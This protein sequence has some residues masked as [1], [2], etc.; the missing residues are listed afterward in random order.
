MTIIE[1]KSPVQRKVALSDPDAS[2]SYSYIENG[3][4]EMTND[5]QTK[6]FG[7]NKEFYVRKVEGCSV[8]KALTGV[9]GLSKGGFLHVDRNVSN[10][11]RDHLLFS[12]DNSIYVLRGGEQIFLRDVNVSDG[13]SIERMAAEQWRTYTH[14]VIGDPDMSAEAYRYTGEQTGAISAFADYSATVAGTI[15][16]TAAAHGFVTGN[17]VVISGTTNYN[18]TY[19][20]TVIDADTFYVTAVWVADDGASVWVGL[21][22]SLETETAMSA[23]RLLG[24]MDETMVSGGVEENSGEGLYSKT[25]VSGEFGDFTS[26]TG[27]GDGGE[28]SGILDTINAMKYVKGYCAVAEENTVTFH[29]RKIE[30]DLVLGTVKRSD[31]QDK[32]LTLT[33]VGTKSPK[34]LFLDSALFILD[35]IRK[36]VFQYTVS[37]RP[38]LIDLGKDIFPSMKDYD[39]SK[40]E[41][42]VDPDKNL[43]L[44]RV[45]SLAGGS[46]DTTLIYNF[47]SKGWSIDVDKN[48]QDMVFNPITRKILAFDTESAQILEIFDGGYSNLGEPISVKWRTRPINGGDEYIEKEYDTS[49]VKFGY[50]SD[51]QSAKINYYIDEQTEPDVTDEFDMPDI[52]DVGAG[53]GLGVWGKN[54]WGEGSASLSSQM[55]FKRKLNEDAVTDFSRLIIEITETSSAPFAAYKPKAVVLP[56][57]NESDNFL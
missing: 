47:K 46:L 26:G 5:A 53:T 9:T 8:H 41:L 3:I 43:L 27:I 50:V 19:I 11:N 14:I 36:T 30:T 56:T 29:K 6:Q 25:K 37:S 4:V 38:S 35:D 12:Y 21:Q 51:T 42:L 22:L 13:Y 31:T 24:F 23:A 10:S 49:S 54:V 20:L 16:V 18:G 39:M 28:L 44:A 7:K 48:F 55:K 15:E 2:V 17:T 33:A 1:K 57:D 32:A 34:G 52:D 45:S 40:G